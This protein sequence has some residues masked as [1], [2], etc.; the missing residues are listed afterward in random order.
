M[1]DLTEV[2]GQVLSRHER[3]EQGLGAFARAVRDGWSAETLTLRPVAG[4][5]DCAPEAQPA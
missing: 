3:L 4:C 5:G 2:Q 1:F